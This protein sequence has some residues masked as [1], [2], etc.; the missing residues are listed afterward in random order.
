MVLASARH[1]AMLLYLDNAASIGPNSRAGRASAGKA[2]AR[3]LNENYARE[4]LELHTVGVNGGYAQGDV[5]E[6]ARVLTGWGVEGGLARARVAAGAVTFGFAPERHEPGARTLLGKRYPDEGVGQGEAVIRD[7]CAH[8]STARFV[9]TK[10]VRHF[11]ADEPPVRAVD[12]VSEVFARSGGDLA[13][14]ASVLIELP[15][16]WDAEN[17]KLRTPQDWVVAAVRAVGAEQVPSN[18]R[19]LLGALRQPLWAPPAPKGW[20]DTRVEWAD[21]DSLMNRAELARRLGKR[22]D[23]G[24]DP[25]SLLDVVDVPPND[26][27]H[28]IIADGSIG[29]GKRVALVL[30]S[31]AFQWR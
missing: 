4:L 15:E 28:T 17:R 19:T 14:T 29:R 18:L 23:R 20:G 11:V 2:R 13:Q 21:P 16:A 3:G 12:A 26:H 22:A 7:L 5:I 10:L 9:A 31:P 1:P 25:A 30:A 6:L 8:P 24:I 27:L